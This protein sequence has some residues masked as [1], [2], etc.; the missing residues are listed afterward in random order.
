MRE[1]SVFGV[2]W[3]VFARIRTEYRNLQEN[4]S[5]F[6]PTALNFGPEILRIRTLSAQGSSI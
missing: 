6:S 2:F 5:V 4:I 1:V 3:S